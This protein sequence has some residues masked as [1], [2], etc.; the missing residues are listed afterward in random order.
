M[1]KSLKKGEK[2]GDRDLTWTKVGRSVKNGLHLRDKNAF[3][4]FGAWDG[5]AVSPLS[6]INANVKFMSVSSVTQSCWR[7]FCPWDFQ[8]RIL[9]GVA[10]SSLRRAS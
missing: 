1:K 3:L 6:C 10:I 5:H 8:A 2:T 9:E 4:S 7:L